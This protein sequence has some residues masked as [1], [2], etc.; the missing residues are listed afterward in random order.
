M[1]RR[2]A[3]I[4]AITATA[5][6]WMGPPGTAAGAEDRAGG[7]GDADPAERPVALY[8]SACPDIGGDEPVRRV[9]A[10][11]LGGRL[12]APGQSLP[13]NSDRVLVSCEGEVA[14][15]DAA[16]IHGTSRVE[17]TVRLGNYPRD[18]APRALALA[19]LEALAALDRQRAAPLAK[20]VA[21]LPAYQE[22]YVW[23]H[24]SVTIF[25]GSLSMGIGRRWSPYLGRY[26][27]PLDG[28]SFYEA[29][30]QPDLAAS[31]NRRLAIKVLLFVAGLGTAIYG[32]SRL[33]AQKSHAFT[34]F[35]AGGALNLAA[36]IVSTDPVDESEARRLADM[37]NKALKASL[38]VSF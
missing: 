4:V 15:I 7:G 27:K 30:N 32:M 36:W 24:D 5:L 13:A 25:Y 21:E 11:E 19:A 17:R 22:R 10:V 29:V 3:T 28:A 6:A 1:K 16:E 2:G 31:Y 26:R 23:F 35:A 8:V 34:V 20:N 12:I 37:H 14:R 9:V 33:S 38:T 18:A